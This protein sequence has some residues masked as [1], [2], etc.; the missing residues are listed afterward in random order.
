MKTKDLANNARWSNF[1]MP[2]HFRIPIK[3]KK[4][5][6]LSLLIFLTMPVMAADITSGESLIAAMRAKYDG[7][8]Y[9]TL[10][11]VQ[12]TT[13]Y[14]ADGSSTVSTWYEAM[15]IPGKLRID[16]D[17]L[18]K[19]GGILF[20]EGRMYSFRDGKPAGRRPFVHPLLV[21]G[22]DVYRQS[23][24]TTL[25]QLKSLN[26]DMSVVHE[27]KWQGKTAY[28]IGAKQGD[29]NSPQI[30]IDKKDLVFVRLFEVVGQ[31]KKS[32]H[33]TQF[34]KYQKI[35][36]GG[37]IAP[38]VQFF[39]DGKRTMLEEYTDIQTGISLNADLWNAEKWMTVDR[40]YYRASKSN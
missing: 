19:G 31:D 17:P 21:L 25:A 1:G 34:N 30:W 28:V 24:E 9:E 29:L 22:F 11:F 39:V 18:E 14:K 38:E 20:S 32:I 5:I 37:W 36:T 4:I 27:E 12:K 40:T 23:V 35:K 2:S 15:K 7:K 8:W 6:F 10:T 3:M 33:E 16:F 26:V 13:E